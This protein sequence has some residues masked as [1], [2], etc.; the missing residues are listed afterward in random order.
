MRYRNLTELA[1]KCHWALQTPACKAEP[2]G[3]EDPDVA[4]LVRAAREADNLLTS[5]LLE[6]GG[7]PK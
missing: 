3:R 1:Y 6:L 7:D 5:A 2:M 4:R